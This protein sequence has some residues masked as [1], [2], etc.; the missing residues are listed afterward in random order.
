M[1]SWMRTDIDF[2]VP[3]KRFSISSRAVAMLRRVHRVLFNYSKDANEGDKVAAEL[4]EVVAECRPELRDVVLFGIQ[5][6]HGMCFTLDV[7]HPSFPRIAMGAVLE[8]ESLECC[9]V[10]LKPMP[11]EGKFWVRENRQEVGIDFFQRVCS[12]ECSA[13]SAPD[14]DEASTPFERA[15]DNMLIHE[16]AAVSISQP[17]KSEFG[18]RVRNEWG[19]EGAWNQT[20]ELGIPAEVLKASGQDA[21]MVN[22]TT[23]GPW[24]KETPVIHREQTLAKEQEEELDRQTEQAVKNKVIT[25]EYAPCYRAGLRRAMLQEKAAIAKIAEGIC[26]GR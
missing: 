11:L 8:V 20:I 17:V 21:R 15:W 25:P 10:C 2:G 6:P 9:P 12:E 7:S 5:Q 22:V 18:V 14:A 23:A 13:R 4:I 1:S 19:N 3:W 26:E 24:W 16:G